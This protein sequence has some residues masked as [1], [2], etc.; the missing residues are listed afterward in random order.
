M[1][2]PAE[3][4]RV[5]VFAMGPKLNISWLESRQTYRDKLF[6][7]FD[8]RLRGPGKPLVQRGADDAASHLRGRRRDLVV[9][10][11][12][13]GLFAALTG[14]RAR[15]A[16]AA[17]SLEAAIA[18]ILGSYAPQ[19]AYYAERFPGLSGRGLP[20]RLLVLTDTFGRTV[21]EPMAEMADRYDVYLRWA[22][23]WRRAGGSCAPTR[24][25]FAT[26][27]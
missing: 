14:E 9:W 19:N 2:P 4:K 11:E 21:V 8:R 26:R 22:W 23:T 10:P 17:G 20:T 6:A 13:V 25:A 12:S 15:T 27:G 24:R 7:L 16:R 5:R 18:T 3:A 1:A